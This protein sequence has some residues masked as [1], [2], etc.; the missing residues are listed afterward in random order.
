MSR[1]EGVLNNNVRAA[2]GRLDSIC[3]VLHK[4]VSVG[5]KGKWPEDL[6]RAAAKLAKDLESLTG[7]LDNAD[8]DS[9]SVRSLISGAEVKLPQDFAAFGR[10]I[11]EH[12]TQAAH[13]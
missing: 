11:A 2:I 1:V 5:E 9:A 6:G 3:D 4:M 12:L 10:A 7:S 13:T 8:E